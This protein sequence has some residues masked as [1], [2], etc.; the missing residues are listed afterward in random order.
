MDRSKGVA[1]QGVAK[2]VVLKEKQSMIYAASFYTKAPI[3]TCFFRRSGTE[4]NGLQSPECNRT[5]G[6]FSF[7]SVQLAVTV[8]RF[9]QYCSYPPTENGFLG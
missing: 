5:K 9:P 8:G 2:N 3:Y 4:R 1:A 6:K 7:R